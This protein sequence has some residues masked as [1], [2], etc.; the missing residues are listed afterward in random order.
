MRERANSFPVGYITS[1]M[2]RWFLTVQERKKERKKH[3]ELTIRLR[4]HHGSWENTVKKKAYRRQ[5]DLLVNIVIRVFD[6]STIS[7]FKFGFRPVTSR[8]VLPGTVL[9]VT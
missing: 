2:L 9:Q 5:E 3:Q 6:V 1:G 8:Y 7:H 4:F